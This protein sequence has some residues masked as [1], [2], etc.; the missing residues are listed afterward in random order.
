MKIFLI[1]FL[2]LF[3][4]IFLLLMQSGGINLKYDEELILSMKI[5][6]LKF[7]LVPKKMPGRNKL[8]SKRYIKKLQ[9]EIEAKKRKEEKKK[10]KK[11]K[12]AL[13]K[14][15]KKKEKMTFSSVM[16]LLK[17]CL[18][19]LDFTS[20]RISVK[21]NDLSIAVSSDDA[22][23]TAIEYGLITQGVTYLVALIR[24]K[25]DYDTESDNNIIVTADYLSGK[26]VFTVDIGASMRVYNVL[27]VLIRGIRS[28][29]IRKLISR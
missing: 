28:N 6:F 11:A 16:D 8:T 1:V 13:K 4:L 10:E 12:K 25:T 22:A 2:S 3:F 27:R 5:S 14:K 29:N 20:G 18:L 7:Q 17:E 15:K 23:K 26:T 19:L 21:I 24:E 9:S